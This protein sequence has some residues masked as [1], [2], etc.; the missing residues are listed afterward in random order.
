MT[1]FSGFSIRPGLFRFFLLF[2]CIALHFHSAAQNVLFGERNLSDTQF[3]LYFDKEGTVYPEYLIA[4]TSL[5]RC[6]GKLVEWYQCHP[7]EFT[8][9]STRYNCTFSAFDVQML[10]VLQDSIMATIGRKINQKAKN[11]VTFLIH[12]YRKSFHEVNTG[13]SSVTEFAGLRKKLDSLE[14]KNELYVEVYWDATYNCCFGLDKKK[15]DSLFR[16]FEVAQQ[17]APKIGLSLRKIINLVQ[18]EKINL[19]AHSLGS[20]V[21][22]S[23]LFNLTPSG[24]PTPANQTINLC[25]VAPAIDGVGIFQHYFDRNTAF[26]YQAKDNYHLYILYN[27]KDFVLRK[28]DNK[29]GLFGPGTKRYGNTTLGCNHRKAVYKLEKHFSKHFPGS[30][31]YTED[32]KILGKNHSLKYYTASAHLQNMVNFMNR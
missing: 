15:N 21:A 20:K 14:L 25:L 31:I 5:N 10:P 32:M 11:T 4:D 18:A 12:G 22:V 8:E 3:A 19:V 7:A 9:I 24:L 30:E 16:L 2:C 13:I 17:S 1:N 28:K 6:A 29:V 27:K 26:D 23:G